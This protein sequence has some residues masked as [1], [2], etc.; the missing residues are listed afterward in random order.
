MFEGHVRVRRDRRRRVGGAR[1]D[2]VADLVPGAGAGARALRE[3]AGNRQRLDRARRRLY[4]STVN[5]A[6]ASIV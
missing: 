1:G 2:R 6:V 4:L 5:E 3:G